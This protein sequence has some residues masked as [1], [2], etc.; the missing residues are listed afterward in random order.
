MICSKCGVQLPDDAKFCKKCGTQVTN[1]ESQQDQQP[2]VEPT[3]APEPIP[4][5]EPIVAPKKSNRAI[6]IT[7]AIL[8]A[9]F[10]ILA[11]VLVV[12]Y[13]KGINISVKDGITITEKQTVTRSKGNLKR[14]EDQVS[15]TP[16]PLTN[17]QN[18]LLNTNDR[19]GDNFNFL[20]AGEDETGMTDVIMIMSFHGEDITCLSIPRDTY[21]QSS[22]S[23]NNKFSAI[24][25]SNRYKDQNLIDAVRDTLG[26]PITYYARISL[27]SVEDVIDCVGGLEYNVPYNMK[28]SDP[29]QNLYINLSKGKQTLTGK[30]VCHLLRYKTYHATGDI[31]RTQ[32]QRNVIREFIDQ[33]M[34]LRNLV[35]LPEICDILKDNII[36]NYPVSHLVGDIDILTKL[37]GKNITYTVIPGRPGLLDEDFHYI[38]DTDQADTILENMIY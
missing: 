25:A 8:G 23:D 35:E 33:K 32:I 34:V 26:I 38:I 29:E 3:P 24:L 12:F 7:I 14:G 18:M 31:S 30:Q 22:Y 6:Y 4:T 21:V 37:D 27:G 10:I 5:L 9:V 28:Y 36:T 16:V 19:N 20:I 15:E 13:F 17:F 11:T 2:P 1:S